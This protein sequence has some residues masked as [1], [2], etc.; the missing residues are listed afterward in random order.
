MVEVRIKKQSKIYRLT[1]AL[2]RQIQI[3]AKQSVALYGDEI[4]WRNQKK[5]PN[6]I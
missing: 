1:S 2:I 6:E 5:H 4:W 3:A